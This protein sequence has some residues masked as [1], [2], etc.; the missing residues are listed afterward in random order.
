MKGFFSLAGRVLAFF[1][2]IFLGTE[3]LLNVLQAP[4][5]QY[6]RDQKV[7]HRYNP[8][9][10]VD[11]AP[12][13][14]IY[15]RHFAGKWEGR[16]RTNSLGMRGLEEPDPE[17]PK[18][19]CLGDSLVMGFGVGDED[20]FCNQLNGIELKGGARQTMNLAVDAYGSLGALRRLKDMAPKLKNLKEVLFFVSANDFTIPEE[21]RNKG[22]LSDDE[23]DEIRDQDPSFN[24]N[25]QIQFELSRA[26]YTLQALKLA[27]EQLKVQYAFTSSKLRS[28][29]NSTGLSPGSTSDQ[30]LSRYMKDSFFRTPPKEDCGSDS[31]S[32]RLEKKNVVVTIPT[33]ETTSKEEYKKQFCP[34]PIPDYF[35]C[36]DREPSLDSLQELPKIT[37]K[38]YDEMVEY[39]RSQGIRLVVVLMPI[40]VEEIFCRN[41]GKYHPLEN[42]ALRAASYFEKK[43]IP[44]LKLRKETSEMCGEVIYTPR[45][46]K[47][48]G[49]RDYF[50]PED[51]HLTVPGNNWAKRA[52]VK[53][54]K[55]LE[56]NAL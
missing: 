8:I 54:L 24:R 55:E 32:K 50:I 7:L 26:S 5:L 30:T 14:D 39:T 52:V 28:E 11:L 13:R 35:T 10:Y 19:A 6:Y 20:T 42:Y 17:K 23:V 43:G 48:S 15:I 4:S 38:A 53:Q 21:L 18:L 36:Q 49:I 51:G 16:F 33:P 37:R 40:Q 29:W 41:R 31:S 9:Y 44:T 25:F 34:E 3:I 46:K 47:F 12:N 45:G 2:I 27:L 56:K 22:M 1:V